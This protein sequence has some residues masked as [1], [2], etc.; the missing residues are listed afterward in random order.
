[1][2]L[3]IFLLGPSLNIIPVVVLV[4]GMYGILVSPFISPVMM[5]TQIYQK[6]VPV[7]LLMIAA[8]VYVMHFKVPVILGPSVQSRTQEAL[9]F[10]LREYGLRS[11]L[12]LLHA[13]MLST[14]VLLILNLYVIFG[15]SERL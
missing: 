5:G 13:S 8:V 3:L 7:R 1:M 9:A 2:G 14:S 11:L 6:A 12:P 4:L 15:V 10:R